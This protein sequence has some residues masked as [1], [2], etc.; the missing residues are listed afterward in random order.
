MLALEVEVRLVMKFKDDEEIE[1]QVGG[2]ISDLSCT[3]THSSKFFYTLELYWHI[4]TMVALGMFPKDEYSP[5]LKHR[6]ETLEEKK[7]YLLSMVI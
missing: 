6:V 7:A 1:Q 3:R 2:L 5:K 4:K